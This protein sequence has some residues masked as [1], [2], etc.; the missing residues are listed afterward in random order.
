MLGKQLLYP[1]KRVPQTSQIIIEHFFSPRLN[2]AFAAHKYVHLGPTIGCVLSYL[3]IEY[4]IF[5][6]L[7]VIIVN[8]LILSIL[9]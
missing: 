5:F 6:E 7:I 3:E 9:K 2:V 1:G 8:C 4:D